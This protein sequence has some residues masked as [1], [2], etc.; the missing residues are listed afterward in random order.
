MRS[1]CGSLYLKASVESQQ[2]KKI[3]RQNIPQNINFETVSHTVDA[4]NCDSNEK[5]DKN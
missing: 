1:V 5:D 4:K 3:N 2:F